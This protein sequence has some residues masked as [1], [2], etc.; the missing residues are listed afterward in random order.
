MQDGKLMV[1]GVTEQG[2]QAME[3]NTNAQS[4]PQVARDEM[5]NIGGIP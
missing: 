3:T 4:F 1:R 5:I 2:L